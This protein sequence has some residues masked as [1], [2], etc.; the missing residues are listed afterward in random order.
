LY[1]CDYENK[2]GN[3][4]PD[5]KINKIYEFYY[6]YGSY[7]SYSTGNN[8]NYWM[9]EKYFVNIKSL[10]RVKLNEIKKHKDE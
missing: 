7:Y 9:I 4:S 5:Y 8:T 3:F 10:R 2:N 1:L 6:D